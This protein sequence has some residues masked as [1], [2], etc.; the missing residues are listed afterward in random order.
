MRLCTPLSLCLAAAALLSSASSASAAPT[1]AAPTCASGPGFPLTTR[2]HDAPD[3]YEAGGGYGTWSL[4]LTNTTT[5][6]CTAVH[7][8]V[9]LVDD[10]R[11]LKPSQARL[12]FSDGARSHPVRFR[13]TD[14]AELVGA[15]DDGF[16][17]FTVG[18]R[19][20]VTVT[21]RLALTSDAEAD[22][23]TANAALVQRHDDDGDWI[24]QSNDYRFRVRHDPPTEP[25]TATAT[26]TA[27]GTGTGTGTDTGTAPPV[28]SRDDL[29]FAD[30]LASTG[31]ATPRTA[32]A[33]T[34][35]LLLAVGG[36]LL[37]AR[38][39]RARR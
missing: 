36:A 25:G 18:P 35:V 13:A 29:P 21:V 4:D 31:I 32:L 15:F 33:A 9:V 17:G 11:T 2:I 26:S 24:G 10:D 6:T 1:P 8:V 28:R 16:P 19:R 3:T 37:L 30:E 27:T 38:R 7:P 34:A 39:S 14:E 22:E 20:T 23:V 12:E 5:R